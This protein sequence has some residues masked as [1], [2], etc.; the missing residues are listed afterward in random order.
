[1]VSKKAI[2]LINLL[3]EGDIKLR[4]GILD[5][6][7]IWNSEED[8]FHSLV[9][10]YAGL[11]NQNIKILQ[12]IL[13]EFHVNCKHPKKMRDQLPDGQQYCM[14]CNLDI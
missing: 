11:L 10:T 12:V 3:L 13:K 7:K 8:Q 4:D 6:S 9:Q 2:F 5:P 14:N 1:M